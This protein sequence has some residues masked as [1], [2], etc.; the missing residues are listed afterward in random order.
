MKADSHIPRPAVRRQC[1][2]LREVPRVAGKIQTAN[3]GTPR[4]SRKKPK[5]GI[6]PTGSLSADVNSNIPCR[7]P[8]VLCRGLE[9]SHAK[10]HGRGTAWYV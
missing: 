9:Q 10:R 5:L 6:S 7:A 3:R 8:A 4:G 2:A 1:H